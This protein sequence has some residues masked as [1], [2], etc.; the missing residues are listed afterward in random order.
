MEQARL[1][2]PSSH[3]AAEC[4]TLMQKQ[5]ITE[6]GKKKSVQL[7]AL[8][9]HQDN[10]ISWGQES[11]GPHE[12]SK[13]GHDPGKASWNEKELAKWVRRGKCFKQGGKIH[14]WRVLGKGKHGIFLFWSMELKGSTE[15]TKARRL[16]LLVTLL[17]LIL[18]DPRDCSPPG[19]SVHGILQARILEW[20]AIPFTRHP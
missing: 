15:I 4:I 3:M 14:V 20:V 2:N 1:Q 8:W 12:R 9:Q 13:E 18:Y 16:Y 10:V 6:R 17:C 11:L 19:S 5:W 7:Q